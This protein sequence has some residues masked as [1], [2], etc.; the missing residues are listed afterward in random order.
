MSGRAA[1]LARVDRLIVRLKFAE[2]C[3]WYG[4]AAWLRMRFD[5]HFR[6]AVHR[7]YAKQGRK[8]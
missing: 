6:R 8:G 4:V 5:R 1:R 3:E 7:A 2:W